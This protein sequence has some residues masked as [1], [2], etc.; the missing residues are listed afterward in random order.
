[1]DVTP[2]DRMFRAMQQFVDAMCG[3]EPSRL[4]IGPQ[5]QKVRERRRAAMDFLHALVAVAMRTGAM[6]ASMERS[7]DASNSDRH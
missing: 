4:M 7:A 6:R 2:T 3:E 1:M 5:A